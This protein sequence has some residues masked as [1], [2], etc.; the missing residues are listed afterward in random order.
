VR[1]PRP[2]PR[3]LPSYPLVL[4]LARTLAVPK[5]V[6]AV[7]VSGGGRG[8]QA[9]EGGLSLAVPYPSFVSCSTSSSV[10][11]FAAMFLKF[12]SS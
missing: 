10:P 12:P 8:T 4:T 9:A 11:L 2:H 5:E 3:P 7:E 1:H 6:Q